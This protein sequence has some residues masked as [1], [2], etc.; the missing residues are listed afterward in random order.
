LK[1]F[2]VESLKIDQ[3]FVRRME[4]NPE[5]AVIVRAIIQLSSSLG[6]ETIAE[7]VETESAADMLRELGCGMAQGYLWSRPLPALEIERF[8]RDWCL[9]EQT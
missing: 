7:G 3:S 8:W 9:L 4:Q 2:E 1:K 6:L 5:D